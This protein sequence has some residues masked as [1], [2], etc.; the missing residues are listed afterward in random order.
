MGKAGY[1]YI[2]EG[3]MKQSK[4]V[5]NSKKGQ[6]FELD[7]SQWTTK[8]SNFK[9]MYD[10]IEDALVESGLAEKL[11]QPVW[12]DMD[13]NEVKTNEE[14]YDQKCSIKTTHPEHVL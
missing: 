8:Y 7:Q 3:F 10:S 2:Q 12:M 6:I 1:K 14:S 5:I 9:Q 13:G 11:A 4:H